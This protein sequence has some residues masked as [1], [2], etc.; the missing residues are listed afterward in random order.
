MIRIVF[1]I[2]FLFVAFN[3][4]ASDIDMQEL[5]RGV[6]SSLSRSIMFQRNGAEIAE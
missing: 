3:A 6:R 4:N 1:F 2:G 5:D